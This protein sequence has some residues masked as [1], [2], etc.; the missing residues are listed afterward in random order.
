MI[1]YPVA[2]CIKCFQW[3]SMGVRSLVKS[4]QYQDTETDKGDAEKSDVLNCM[5]VLNTVLQSTL[6][7][8]MSIYLFIYLLGS[9]IISRMRLVDSKINY[10]W[11]IR[12]TIFL[13]GMRSIL[14]FNSNMWKFFNRF[15]SHTDG[16]V[17]CFRIS[18]YNLEFVDLFMT[19]WSWGR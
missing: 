19:V 13:W 14:N 10:I 9:L 7:Y 16:H 8:F 18:W 5:H 3:E 4:C 17:F 1:K 11:P 15:G 6:C 2:L 12:A